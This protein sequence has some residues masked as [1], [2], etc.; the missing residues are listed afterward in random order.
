MSAKQP[1]CNQI[2]SQTLSHSLVSSPETEDQV[3]SGLLLDV[4]VGEGPSVLEL[5]A[6]ED[7]PLLVRGDA[8]L[9]LD[10]GLDVLD[11]VGWLDLKGDG[12]ASQGL[13]EDLHTSPETEDKVESGLLLDVVV[14][15]G[16]AVLKLLASEDQ[17]LLVRG[18][19]F[20]VLDLGLDVLD[21]VGG[22]DLKGD[23]LASQGLDEDLH[24]SPKT[25]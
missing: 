6:S 24:P 10:L 16:P 18:D 12:L 11:G 7:Q 8:L 13:D 20:L 3:E 23:G 15:E 22:L 9:V 5:L 2:G 14:G 25:E 19:A 17:P 4:V 21:G 1:K